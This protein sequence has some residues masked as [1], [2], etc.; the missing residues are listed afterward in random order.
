M[1]VVIA[2]QK[3]KVGYFK[4]AVDQVDWKSKSIV[5]NEE[6]L[7]EDSLGY[8]IKTIYFISNTNGDLTIFVDPV[9]DGAFLVY[10][11]ISVTAFTPI[12]YII[13]GGA[14]YIKLKFSAAATVT[15]KFVF[16]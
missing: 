11:T 7:G 16:E 1:M 14:K 6:T 5:A 10:D 3:P 4:S 12:T 9:G 2:R 13:T 15:A 8:T